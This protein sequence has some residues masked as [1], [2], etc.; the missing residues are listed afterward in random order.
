[1]TKLTA[2][3]LLIGAFSTLTVQAQN[4][5][6]VQ[7]KSISKQKVTTAPKA[8]HIT[9]VKTD[10]KTLLLKE[11]KFHKFSLRA[12]K[13]GYLPNVSGKLTGVFKLLIANYTFNAD[14]SITLDPK[15][16]EEQGVKNATWMLTD[17]GKLKIT[18]FWTAEKQEAAGYT[19]DYEKVRY[20]IDFISNNELTISLSDMFIVNLV[21]K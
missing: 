14:G 18:Y 1:M 2:I 16:M 19:N 11:W 12:L 13:D 4:S 20:K 5:K 7:A 21:T 17:E 10:V 9:T 15:Y 6:K 3:V 8:E